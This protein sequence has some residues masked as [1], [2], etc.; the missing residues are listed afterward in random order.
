MKPLFLIEVP[1]QRQAFGYWIRTLR[2]L[3]SVAEFSAS[4]N[5]KSKLWDDLDEAGSDESK[6]VDVCLEMIGHDLNSL[7]VVE[8]VKTEY[9]QRTRNYQRNGGCGEHQGF[10]ILE[11]LQNELRSS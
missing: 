9:R 8:S 11:I 7:L 4:D 3:E 1:H 5:D 6:R 2:E 10:R